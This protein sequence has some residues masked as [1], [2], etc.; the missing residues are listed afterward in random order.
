MQAHA[1]P[2]RRWPC[3]RAGKSTRTCRRSTAQFEHNW[4]TGTTHTFTGGFG[5]IDEGA[6]AEMDMTIIEVAFHDSVEDAELMRD[7]KVRDQ[8]ARS[9]YE[10]TLEYFDNLGGL[11]TPGE[12][13]VGAD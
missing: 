6:S 7:P 9:T 10:A 12:P 1:Q 4:S 13:A 11:A 3:T 8:I 2:S 5:E